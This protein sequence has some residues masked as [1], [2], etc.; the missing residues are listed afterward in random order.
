MSYLK[1]LFYYKLA[2]VKCLFGSIQNPGAFNNSIKTHFGHQTFRFPRKS[3]GDWLIS[4]KIYKFIFL[5]QFRKQKFVLNNASGKSAI[6]DGNLNEA[7]K[8]INYVFR[9]SG[10]DPGIVV[11]RTEL[12][13]S[14]SL[15]I[16]IL[17]GL[18]LIFSFPFIFALSLFSSNKLRYPFHVLNSVE[19]LNMLYLLRKFRINKLHFFCIYENDANLMAYVLMKCGIN[20]NKISSESPLAFWNKTVVA[21]S[22]SIC[23]HYQNDEYELFKETMHVKKLQEWVPENSFDLEQHYLK[24]NHYQNTG[25]IGFY[26]SAMWLRQELGRIDLKDNSYMNEQSLFKFLL[27]YLNRNSNYKLIVFL[28]PLEKKNMERTKSYYGDL[29]KS[30]ELADLSKPNLEQFYAADVGVTLFS[31]LSYERLFWGFKTLIYPLGYDDF[32]INNSNFNNV[33][34]KSEREL[35]LRLGAALDV[36]KDEFF[37][38][39]SLKGYRYFENPVFK[40]KV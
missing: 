33:C 5:S 26:S 35:E 9:L 32:P 15:V 16:S 11:A 39:N 7:A 10:D 3:V 13:N 27:Q 22:L 18:S 6:F 12:I 29:S 8:R 14:P 37:D 23:F 38:V 36:G 19:A 28:H 24:G 40:Q 17:V 31:S 25:T 1:L 2:G 34:P 20:I 21:D 4:L 30:I